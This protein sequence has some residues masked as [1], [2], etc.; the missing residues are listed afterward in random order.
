MLF[1]AAQTYTRIEFDMVTLN[2]SINTGR[3]SLIESP[4]LRLLLSSFGRVMEVIENRISLISDISIVHQEV[5]MKYI[6][7]RDF[8][9]V[10]FPELELGNSELIL[11]G[12]DIFKDPLF[13]NHI[14]QKYWFNQELEELYNEKIIAQVEKALELMRVELE[15]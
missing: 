1:T 14:G 3:I 12:N 15:M 10:Y 13:E 9:D 4:E 6:P 2:E 5:S 7:W 8:D 11:N